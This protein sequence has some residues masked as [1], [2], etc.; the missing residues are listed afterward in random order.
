MQSIGN[1]EFPHEVAHCLERGCDGIGL[2]RTEFLYLGA[3]V[4]PTEEVH[5][6]A[7]AGVVQ[8]MP[9]KPVVI[10]TL[11]SGRR[12][13][14]E[15][16]CEAEA[17]PNPFL[18]SAQHPTFAAKSG[19]VSHAIAGHSAGQCLGDVR[20]MFPLISTLLELRQAK[21]VLADVMEDLQEQQIPFNRRDAKSA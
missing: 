17:E 8:A 19:A 11:R 18:G 7:Y 6:N 3:D 12:Q 21:M 2:Y 9:G 13:V 10:R 4:E 20:I 5:Y 16:H 14:D 15:Q 1:I